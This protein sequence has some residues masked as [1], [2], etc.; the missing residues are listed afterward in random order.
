MGDRSGHDPKV[1]SVFEVVGAYFCDTM[2]NHI[3]LGAAGAGADRAADEYV[4]R[5]RAYVVGVKGDAQCY[6]NVVEGVHAYFAGVTS[7]AALSYAEFVDRVVGVCVP[8]EYFR[9]LTTAHK[10]ELL[11]SVVCDLVAALGAYVTRPDVLA[12][13]VGGHARAP[14]ATVRA[15]QDAAVGALTAK[16]GALFNRFL[17]AV[18][19]V[20]DQVP[21][22]AVA[23]LKAA[24]RRLVRDKADL[25]AEVGRLTDALAAAR[26]REAKFHKLLALVRDGRDR[27]A[28]AAG[29]AL[30]AAEAATGIAARH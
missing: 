27:G 3:Y 1:V 17:G 18:G 6:Q 13:V 15:M 25:A 30:A 12:R 11:S 19:E 4:R 9:Q 8:A 28:A 16:R 2:F 5:V 24:L 20:R 21:A 7:Y 23:D 22:S 26:G 14:E 10:D 29:A